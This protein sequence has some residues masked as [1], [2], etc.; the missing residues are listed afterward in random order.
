VLP[1][2]IVFEAVV[3]KSP[4]KGGWTYLVWDKSVETFGTKGRVKVRGTFDSQPFKSSFMAM[5][6]GVHKLP[7]TAAMLNE[8]GKSVGDNI[9]VVIT[10]RL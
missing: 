8:L 5:G 6:G 4:K 9:A 1:V 10:E 2:N 7:I 3:Q